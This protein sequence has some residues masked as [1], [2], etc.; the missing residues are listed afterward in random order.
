MNVVRL[1][2]TVQVQVVTYLLQICDRTIS[3]GRNSETFVNQS[4]PSACV[5]VAR[6]PIRYKL[7][8]LGI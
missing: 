5:M 7:N 6:Q 2:Q 8:Q 4:R 3:G 1:F